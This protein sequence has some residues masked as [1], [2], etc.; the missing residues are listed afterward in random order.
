MHLIQKTSFTKS[1]GFTL[2]NKKSTYLNIFM[3]KEIEEK[4]IQSIATTQNKI[5]ILS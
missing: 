5:K 2:K 1:H 3:D 4:S